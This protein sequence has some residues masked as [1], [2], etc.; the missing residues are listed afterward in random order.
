M[1]LGVACFPVVSSAAR[2]NERVAVV[3]RR[4]VLSHSSY[5]YIAYRGRI[6]RLLRGGAGNAYL[7]SLSTL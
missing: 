3:G 4:A 1:V 2:R 5:T 6:G 7:A